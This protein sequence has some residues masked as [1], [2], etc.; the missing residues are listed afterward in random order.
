MKL[1]NCALVALALS[2][3]GCGSESPVSPQ[4]LSPQVL[5]ISGTVHY[6]NG[7]TV[8]NAPVWVFVGEKMVSSTQA[9]PAGR[10]AVVVPTNGERIRIWASPPPPP[11]GGFVA[12]TYSGFVDVSVGALDRILGR[13]TIDIVLDLYVA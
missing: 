3:A 7:T 5:Q 13:I 4:V 6:P 9:D 2:G 8:G 11:P 1:L 10:F 12:G